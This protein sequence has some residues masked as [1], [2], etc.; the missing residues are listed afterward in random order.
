MAR[1]LVPVVALFASS[2]NEVGASAVS[3]NLKV[4]STAEIMATMTVPR[5][6]DLLFRSPNV[7][8]RPK[9]LAMLKTELAKVN[10]S[11]RVVHEHNR[12]EAVPENEK[13]YGALNGAR[14]MLNEMMSD[15]GAKLDNEIEKCGTYNRETLALLEEI[16]Q[17]VASFNA[18]AADARSR[19]LKSQ[20]TIAFCQLKLPQVQEE[21]DQHNEE[22]DKE[23]A[24]LKSQIDIVLGDLVVM[25]GIL[26]MV[27]SCDDPAAAVATLVQCR[28]CRKV[29]EGGYMMLQNATIQPLLNKLRSA[30]VRSYVQEN[31]NQ[32]YDDVVAKQPAEVLTQEEVRHQIALMKGSTERRLRVRGQR[33]DPDDE[34][35]LDA[36]GNDSEALNIS[37][38]PEATV[39]YDCIPTNKCTLGKGSCVKIRDRFLNIQAGIRDMLNMLKKELMELQRSC[40]EDRVIMESQVANLGEKLRT[41]QTDLATA[42]TDQVSSESSSNLKA[43]QHTEVS[44]EY[45]T[46]MRE[47]C[48]EQNNLKSEICALEKIRGELYKM[49][50]WEV[51]ITDCEVSEWAVD[52]CSDSCGGGYLTKSRS[53]MVHPV[54]GMACPPLELKESCNTHHCPIDCVVGEWEGWSG[55][56]AECGGGVRSR[57]RPVLMEMKYDGQPCEDTEEA[58]GCGS[59]SCNKECELADWTKWGTCT[60]ACWGGTN[61]R[62]RPVLNEAVGTGTC[63]EPAGEERLQFRKC[64]TLPCSQFYQE[65]PTGKFLKC[66][67]KLDLIILMDG[68]GSLGSRGWKN[69]KKLVT[70]LVSNLQG[71]DDHVK[72]A[73]QLFSGPTT[74]DD[75]EKCTGVKGAAVPDMEKDCHISWVKHLSNDTMGVAKLVGDLQWPEATTLTSVA[76]AEA[77]AELMYGRED[78]ASIVVV[79]TDGKPMSKSRTTEAVNALKAKARVIW[80]PVGP[81][82]PVEFVEELASLPKE[83]NIIQI[84][85]FEK[86]SWSYFTNKII[87]QSCPELVSNMFDEALH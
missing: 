16:R 30:A 51:F 33:Q 26:K 48:D 6:S 10:E 36:M 74:W 27:G 86:L 45:G 59:Q 34:E 21:L 46:T 29:N 81:G 67:S 52:K 50:G 80:V 1:F 40:M 38:V 83:E 31:L 78:A 20:G 70:N 32:A 11:V 84:D 61:R 37:E 71:G 3:A 57:M 60:Q 8:Q 49:R 82:A 41:G 66:A 43:Q 63:P 18:Q 56:S 15:S 53:V 23:E 44:H 58:E 85:D 87:A 68:S 13:G 39:P 62:D 12:Y 75:Y 76:L 22:C 17:D 5:A 42:T 28:H 35:L 19:V 2:V 4:F 79:I 47:C 24:S 65:T 64:N 9:L 77:E 73:L 69:S 55:C 54:N 72:V 7:L 14:D 25:A